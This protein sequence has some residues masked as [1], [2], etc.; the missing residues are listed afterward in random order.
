M[1]ELEFTQ[2]PNNTIKP[3]DYKYGIVV[4]RFQCDKPHEGHMALLHTVNNNHPEMIIFLGIPH[5]QDTERDP[6]NFNLRKMMLEELFPQATIL[7]IKDNNCDIKWSKELDKQIAMVTNNSTALLYGG[8]DSFKQYYQGGYSVLEFSRNIEI[9]A[10]DRRNKI[11][12]EELNDINFR[13]GIIHSKVNQRPVVHPTVDI[14]VYNEKGQILLGR[15][16]YEDKFRCIGGFVD[17][18]DK[19]YEH[20][21]LRE[22]SEETNKV[23]ISA[24]NYVCSM[25]VDDP[26]YKGLKDGIM[27]TLLIGQYMFGNPEPTDDISEIQWCSIDDLNDDEKINHKI[28]PVHVELMKYLLDYIKNKE[29]F[30]HIAK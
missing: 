27:T 25:N 18:A 30:I 7:P 29:L 15:K 3:E 22:H 13:R 23:E 12:S 28:M 6:L 20:A 10:T 17:K 8:R 14:V 16:P 4:G 19:S 9:S 21:G 24:L 1:Q 5:I 2:D 26:R 11:G